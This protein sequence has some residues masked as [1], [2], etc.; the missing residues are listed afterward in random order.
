VQRDRLAGAGRFDDRAFVDPE[1][2]LLAR[3]DEV[4]AQVAVAGQPDATAEHRELAAEPIETHRFGG[5]NA[6]QFTIAR[7][8]HRRWQLEGPAMKHLELRIHHQSPVCDVA[9]ILDDGLAIQ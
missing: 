3:L 7:V 5:G 6:Q 8:G 2:D 4:V 1:A 9:I